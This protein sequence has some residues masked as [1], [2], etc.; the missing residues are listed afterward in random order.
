MLFA[1]VR[2]A[3]ARRCAL[4]ILLGRDVLVTLVSSAVDENDAFEELVDSFVSLSRL[5]S[6]PCMEYNRTSS[7][8]FKLRVDGDVFIPPTLMS[9][10]VSPSRMPNV[11][12]DVVEVDEIIL[13]ASDIALSRAVA[14]FCVSD[15]SE[16]SGYT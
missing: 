7:I 8:C 11:V 16:V 14:S 3:T 4:N 13:P 5:M 10:L 12:A 15:C 9:V 1:Y 6:L 2:V